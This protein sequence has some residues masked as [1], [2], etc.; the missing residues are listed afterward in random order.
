MKI[1]NRSLYRGSHPRRPSMRENMAARACGRED[2]ARVGICVVLNIMC[3][4]SE[5]LHFV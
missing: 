1:N 3:I 5:L 2:A 4:V